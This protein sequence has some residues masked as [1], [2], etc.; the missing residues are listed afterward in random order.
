M[1]VKGTFIM[2]SM[3]R[4]QMMREIAQMRIL[5]QISMTPMS[6]LATVLNLLLKRL[7]VSHKLKRWS[8]DKGIAR[9]QLHLTVIIKA[10]ALRVS[11]HKM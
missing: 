8:V 1:A 9:H 6:H 5:L 10:A 3:K 2:T 11:D 7:K 4:S